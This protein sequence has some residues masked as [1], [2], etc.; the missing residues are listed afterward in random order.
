[1]NELN[2]VPKRYRPHTNTYTY[3]RIYVYIFIFTI[4]SCALFWFLFHGVLILFCCCCFLCLPVMYLVF[5]FS[6]ILFRPSYDTI[7]ILLCSLYAVYPLLNFCWSCVLNHRT[8]Q[9]EWDICGCIHMCV[10]VCVRKF[11]SD[12]NLCSIVSLFSFLYFLIS[13][14]NAWNSFILENSL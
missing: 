11:P 4:W 14:Q 3:V 8:V 5:S 7:P 9:I 12:C 1:M 6:S 13:L 2:R 10:C